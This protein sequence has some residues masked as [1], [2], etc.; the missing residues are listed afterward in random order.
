M[1]KERNTTAIFIC[2]FLFFFCTAVGVALAAAPAAAGAGAGVV[3]GDSGAILNPY[4]Q[5]AGH[6]SASI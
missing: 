4:R 1:Q 5:S 6:I 3:A 2:L